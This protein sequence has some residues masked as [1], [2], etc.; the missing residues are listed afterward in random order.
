[1]AMR[2]FE[3]SANLD[4]R[5][6]TL[7][8]IATLH[9][10][11]LP[12]DELGSLLPDGAPSAPAELERWVAADPHR[13]RVVDDTILPPGVGVSILRTLDDRRERGEVYLRHASRLFAGPLSP[14][15][16]L[17]RCAGVTGSTAY[18]H[19]SKGDDLDLM[20]ITARG[21]LWAFLAVAF[22]KFRLERAAAPP[23]GTAW[24]LNYVLDERAAAALYAR[25]QGLLFAREALMVRMVRGEPYYR[26]LLHRS[27]WISHE[28]PR[29]Y[30]RL[31]AHGEAPRE[32]RSRPLRLARLAS[33]VIFPFLATYLQLVGLYRN[34]AL[35]CRG[36]SDGQFRTVT[37]PGEFSLK[38]DRYVRLNRLYVPSPADREPGAA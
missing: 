2:R 21:V 29:L 23:A 15:E 35:R 33:S 26:S 11:G 32:E 22:L 34:H 8:E 37:L 10:T 19:P 24:C 31:T 5:V 13:G 16:P 7:L 9:R 30:R 3:E 28:L 14:V 18:R 4:R 38:T 20:A 12:L 17:V 36:R 27:T 1:M 25:P 6:S